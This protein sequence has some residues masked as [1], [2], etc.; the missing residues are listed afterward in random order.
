MATRIN[1]LQDTV[2]LADTDY[3]AVDQPAQ[4]GRLTLGDLR[5]QM[6]NINGGSVSVKQFGAVGDGVTDDTVAIQAALDTASG[7]FAN[8]IIPAN[9][10]FMVS[11]RLVVGSNTSISGKGT[12]AATSG[13]LVAN[14]KLLGV[15]AGVDNVII[16]DIT[17][18]GNGDLTPLNWLYNSTNVSFRRVSFI[19]HTGIALFAAENASDIVIDDCTFNT[20]GFSTGVAG[21]DAKQAIAFGG[22]TS[23][24]DS[25][26]ITN[27]KFY[28]IGLDCISFGSFRDSRITGNVHA[29]EN[30]Y[31]LIYSGGAGIS[32]RLIISDNVARTAVK[33]VGSARP[34]GIGIDLPKISDSVVSNNVCSGCASAGLGIF[35]DGSN[36][37]VIGN[38]CNDNNQQ[39]VGPYESGIV[40]KLTTGTINLSGNIC[41]NRVGSTQSQGIVYDKN[42]EGNIWIGSSNN[43]VNNPIQIQAR[44]YVSPIDIG[45]VIYSAGFPIDKTGSGTPE[46]IVTAP[47]GSTY[48]RVDGGAGTALYVKE[49][50][51]GNT[52][53]VAK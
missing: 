52:G 29:D 7:G 23:T 38:V 41:G 33:V 6:G 37:D 28:S 46:G 2:T 39:S 48:R 17:L 35:L 14:G 20:I 18:E 45:T 8:I 3:I 47:V 44:T 27:N 5:D 43:L 36:V 49:S 51:T 15:L 1:S 31:A 10:K 24:H 4:T 42:Q 13:N 34:D 12:I 32:S 25:I 53:W 19:N 16:E 22:G 50:G 30:C 11:Q 21:A 40:V 9:H 26:T